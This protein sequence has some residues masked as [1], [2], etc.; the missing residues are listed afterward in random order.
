M[1]SDQNVRAIQTALDSLG[2]RPILR[3]GLF[4]PQTRRLT[5]EWLNNDGRARPVVATAPLVPAQVSGAPRFD[6]P[7]RAQAVA[8]FGPAGGPAATRGRCRLPFPMPLAWD[9]SQRITSFACHELLAA[10]FTWVHQEAAR[11]YGEIRFRELGL[12]QWGG[13]FNHRPVRGGTAVSIHSFGAANDTDPVR[14]GLHTPSVRAQLAQPEY[15]DWWRIV[16]ATGALSFG[17]RHGR[18][19]MHWGYVQE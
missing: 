15:R 14:N 1:T 8:R 13:C 16:E 12:D 11:H 19:W 17:K 10:H 2:Y 6:P 7:T 3:D 4:G 18:D 5:E 9:Q